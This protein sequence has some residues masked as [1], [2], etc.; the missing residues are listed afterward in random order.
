MAVRGGDS[1]FLVAKASWWM[2]TGGWG[3]A[4]EFGLTRWRLVAAGGGI[5]QQGAILTLSIDLPD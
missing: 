5:L 3:R 1:E 2:R 4:K